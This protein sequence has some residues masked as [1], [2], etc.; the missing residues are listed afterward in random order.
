MRE[1]KF[2]RGFIR[3]LHLDRGVDLWLRLEVLSSRNGKDF[4]VRE[5]E[6]KKIK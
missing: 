5:N 3:Y 1:K 2:T 6:K 4:G